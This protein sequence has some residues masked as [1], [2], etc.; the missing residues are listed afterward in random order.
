MLDLGRVA[1][2]RDGG[3][4]GIALECPRFGERYSRS[5]LNNR[6]STS[7]CYTK[8]HCKGMKCALPTWHNIVRRESYS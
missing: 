8:S 6:S 5:V 1:R 4:G 2:G 7:G 3:G